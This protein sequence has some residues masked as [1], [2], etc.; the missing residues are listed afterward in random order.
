MESTE[1]RYF[2]GPLNLSDAWIMGSLTSI[3]GHES[4]TSTRATGQLHA[5]AKPTGCASR[6]GANDE[7]PPLALLPCVRPRNSAIAS[8]PASC[9]RRGGGRIARRTI[10]ALRS[11]IT[12]GPP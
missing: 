1:R 11:T 5:V 2:P 12:A 3:A 9:P 7:P 8:P 10:G 6:L 4:A